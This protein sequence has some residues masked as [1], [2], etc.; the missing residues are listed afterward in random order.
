M[1]HELTSR[2]AALFVA[3]RLGVGCVGADGEMIP[4]CTPRPLPA[5]PRTRAHA[6]ARVSSDDS[7]DSAARAPW[8]R[9][10]TSGDEL[11]VKGTTG[12]ALVDDEAGG[13]KGV[14]KIG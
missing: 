3:S 2:L 4:G 7:D 14:K 13:A 6:A 11:P 9:C 8:E 1:G 5:G 10:Y 12:W